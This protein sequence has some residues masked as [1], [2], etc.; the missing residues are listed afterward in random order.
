MA[1][2]MLLGQLP[3]QARSRLASPKIGPTMTS[4]EGPMEPLWNGRSC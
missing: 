3:V 1:E 4:R 2:G